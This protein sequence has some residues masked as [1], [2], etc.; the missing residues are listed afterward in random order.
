L[1]ALAVAY[2]KL[3]ETNTDKYSG[4]REAVHA[5]IRVLEALATQQVKDPLPRR[6]A[7]TGFAAGYF[8]KR[9][10]L[11]PDHLPFAGVGFSW[12]MLLPRRRDTALGLAPRQFTGAQ[13]PR[14]ACH[15]ARLPTRPIFC[16][17]E[18]PFGIAFRCEY[19]K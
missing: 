4:L 9:F 15:P 8:L 11:I 16:N 13:A 12:I 7:E 6:L 18:A 19:E 1:R 3:K 17:S 14:F 10:D 5:F 2:W